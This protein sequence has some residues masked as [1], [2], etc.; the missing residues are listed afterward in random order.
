MDAGVS[1]PIELGA[2]V[3]AVALR[4]VIGLASAGI[5]VVLANS[6]IG[7]PALV[8]IGLAALMSVGAPASP[9]PALV[10]LLVAV[11]VVAIGGNPFAPWVLVL[12]PLVHLLHVSCA[13]AGLM[14]A[15][16]RI[17]PSAL[18]PAALRFLAI[19]AGVFALAGL[20]AIAPTGRVPEALEMIAVGGIAAIAIILWR[21]L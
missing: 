6:G 15:R 12:V 7:G 5:V 18:R 3:P 19:Q 17:R 8:V 16:A 4:G 2:G 11:S 21:L 9:A 10:V 20:I 14:P 1:S 13:V